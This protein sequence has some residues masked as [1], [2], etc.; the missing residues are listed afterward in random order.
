VKLIDR[1][2]TLGQETG[3]LP[4]Q[5]LLSQERGSGAGL[6]CFKPTC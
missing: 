6:P 3:A 2:G 4:H 5:S 1:S